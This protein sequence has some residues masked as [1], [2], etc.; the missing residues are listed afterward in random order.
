MGS[1]GN[2]GDGRNDHHRDARQAGGRTDEIRRSARR[3]ADTPTFGDIS[4]QRSRRHVGRAGRA[5]ASHSACQI[6]NC[7][8]RWIPVACEIVVRDPLNDPFT[9]EPVNRSPISNDR[10][11]AATR[12]RYFPSHCRPA[13]T[14][15]IIRP[16]DLISARVMPNG[17][18]RLPAQRICGKQ[19][20]DKPGQCMFSCAL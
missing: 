2:A 20:H 7:C 16:H 15:A 3:R 11:V 12:D 14:V 9:G 13:E 6:G 17:S 1:E 19:R 8:R 5:M 10:H 4:T 18:I